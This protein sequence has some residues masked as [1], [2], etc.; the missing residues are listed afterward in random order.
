[1]IENTTLEHEL[2]AG[3]PMITRTTGRSM[4]PLLYEGKTHVV[5]EP[6]RAPLVPGDLPVYR[7]PD[8]VYIIHRLISVRDGVFRTRGDNCLTGEEVPQAW[9]VGIVTQIYRRGKIIHVTDPAY[10]RYVRV[11][12]ALWPL[13]SVWYRL[14]WRP[15]ALLR[16]LRR[17]GK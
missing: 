14:R 11:W 3:R 10:R 6:L 17:S 2:R 9:M 13:R 8:G 1:M 16:R 12:N 5:I 15:A 4:E 7:R